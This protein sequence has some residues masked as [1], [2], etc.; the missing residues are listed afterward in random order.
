MSYEEGR[1]EVLWLEEWGRMIAGSTIVGVRTRWGGGFA[2]CGLFW[3]DAAWW[4][5]LVHFHDRAAVRMFKGRWLLIISGRGLLRS[6][7]QSSIRSL[8]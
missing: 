6:L 1:K 3:L 4:A 8:Q 7:L 2:G 5:G